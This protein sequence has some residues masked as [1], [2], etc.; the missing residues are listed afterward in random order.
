M[1]SPVS[2]STVSVKSRLPAPGYAPQLPYQSW[3]DWMRTWD[4]SPDERAFENVVR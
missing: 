4:L 2:A 3:R 1:E